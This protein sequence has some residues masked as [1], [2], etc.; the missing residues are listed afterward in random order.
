V[1]VAVGHVLFAGD[2]VEESGPPAFEDAHPAEWAPTLDRVLK[3]VHGPVVPG[4]G[5]PVDREPDPVPWTVLMLITP[6]PPPASRRT[7]PAVCDARAVR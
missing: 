5:R 7:P 6:P 1:T 2:L 3:Q 4:H